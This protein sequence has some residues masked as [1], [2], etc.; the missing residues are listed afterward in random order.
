MNWQK[1]KESIY[2]EDGS[3]RDIYILE[4]N[5]DDWKKWVC[6]VNEHYHVLF[7]ADGTETKHDKIPWT[8]I[9]GRLSGNHH[10]SC[11]AS[12]YIDSIIINAFFF[13]EDQIEN[14]ITPSEITTLEAH[15]KLMNYMESV[16]AL[17]NKPVRLTEENHPDQILVE[18][19]PDRP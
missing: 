5:K 7:S 8:M 17:L 18:V 1:I 16:A 4:T 15:K 12:I 9:E 11:R 13:T 2:Y 6:F 14:D 3:L 10:S 19:L